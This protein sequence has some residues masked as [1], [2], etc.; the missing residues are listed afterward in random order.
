MLKYL[1]NFFMCAIL[2]LALIGC[3]NLGQL[4][5]KQTRMLKNQGFTL[6][7][8]GWTLSLPQNLLFDFDQSNIRADQRVELEALAKRLQNYNLNKVK[9]VGHTDDVGNKN[10]NKILSAKRA[11]SVS[12]IF[13]AAGFNSNNLQSI[14]RGESQPLLDNNNAKNRALNRRVNIIIIP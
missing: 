8:E 11:S 3:S 2:G 12:Q 14:G 1:F 4:N 13:L 10:Y 6:S 5:Y 9:I 7:E